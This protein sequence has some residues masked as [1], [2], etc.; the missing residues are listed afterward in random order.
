M[1][2]QRN[3][4]DTALEDEWYAVRYSGEIPEVAQVMHLVDAV[5]LRYLDI[6]ERDLLPA[7]RQTS[8][9]RGIRRAIINWSRFEL[10][11]DSYDLDISEEKKQVARALLHFLAREIKDMQSPEHRCCINCS[12]EELCDFSEQLGLSGTEHLSP[13]SAHCR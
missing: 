10:F 11:C 6:I 13:L 12:F 5:R 3:D 8:G 9:Y 7:N 4:S 2:I 1:T